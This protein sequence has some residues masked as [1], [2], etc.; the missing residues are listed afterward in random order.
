MKELGLEPMPLLQAKHVQECNKSQHFGDLE[1]TSQFVSDSQS[2]EEL[3][4]I[5]KTSPITG[6]KEY[7]RSSHRT[8]SS[9]YKPSS[10]IEA[11]TDEKL[12]STISQEEEKAKKFASTDKIHESAALRQESVKALISKTEINMDLLEEEVEEDDIDEN[13][14]N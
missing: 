9:R 2:Y 12:I 3:V 8:S 11:K 7:Y 4:V 14:S 6:V 13:M 1:V 5:E 10:F